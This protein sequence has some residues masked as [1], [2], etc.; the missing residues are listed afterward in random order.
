MVMEAMGFSFYLHGWGPYELWSF[1]FDVGC[2]LSG[3]AHG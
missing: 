1:I 2:H 3:R